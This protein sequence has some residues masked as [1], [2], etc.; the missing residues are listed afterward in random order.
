MGDLSYRVRGAYFESC[1]CEAICPCRMVGGFPGERS[2]YGVCYGVLSWSIAAGTVGDV[3]VGGLAAALVY[4][5]DDD[6]AGSPW[7]VT[8]HV[9]DRG[10]DKQR[11]A[12]KWLF[13]DG[14][15]QLPW[16]RKARHLIGVQTSAVEID[17]TSLR[18]ASKVSMRASRFVPTEM[19]VA[20]GI[21]GYERIGYELYADELA[22]HDGQF[23]WELTGNCA[24]ASD[25]DYASA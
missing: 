3:E 15:H 9:D 17:G 25:F 1:N 5:Y 18:V 6:E 20:C 16:I 21:P 7:S 19:R 4:S 12:L 22:V 13:L 2:T 8:L 11:A 23:D 24:Y 10:N 14:L